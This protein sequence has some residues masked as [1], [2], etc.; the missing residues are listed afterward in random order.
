MEVVY[1]TTADEKEVDQAA[2]VVDCIVEVVK[3]LDGVIV[4][5]ED[6]GL[7]EVVVD[8]GY[9]NDDVVYHPLSR[10]GRPYDQHVHGQCKEGGTQQ[11]V[12]LC[13]LR[14]NAKSSRLSLEVGSVLEL[15]HCGNYRTGHPSSEDW[16]LV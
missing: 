1:R 7:E 2:A 6:C 13:D 15:C 16:V 10:T 4:G 11:A 14:H 12:G 9:Q 5:C 3:L 8:C